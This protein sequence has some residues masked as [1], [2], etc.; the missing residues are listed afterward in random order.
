MDVISVT[1]ND[2]IYAARYC[3]DGLLVEA[4]LRIYIVVFNGAEMQL[5][6]NNIVCVVGFNTRGYRTAVADILSAKFGL[7]T[8]PAPIIMMIMAV[9][10]DFV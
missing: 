5:A 2:T 3:K 1:N 8:H 9:A 7:P 4:V 10:S 6:F